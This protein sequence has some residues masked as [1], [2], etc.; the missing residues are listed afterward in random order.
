MIGNNEHRTTKAQNP[1]NDN[2]ETN[3]TSII[4]QS[5]KIR[6]LEVFNMVRTTRLDS[7]NQITT[8]NN[9]KADNF[10]LNFEQKSTQK[11]TEKST[12]LSTDEN[13]YERPINCQGDHSGSNERGERRE[14][15]ESY[16]NEEKLMIFCNT[17]ELLIK[18]QISY[19]KL[20][21]SKIK[22]ITVDKQKIFISRIFHLL[23]KK[24][25]HKVDENFINEQIKYYIV[26]EKIYDEGLLSFI[27]NT[28]NIRVDRD[29]FEEG[30]KSTQLEKR[31]RLYLSIE[32][33]F[34]LDSI[35]N[36]YSQLYSRNFMR[37]IRWY[38][39]AKEYKAKLDRLAF[40]FD[41]LENEFSKKKKEVFLI[42][43]RYSGIKAER[44]LHVLHLLFKNREWKF[45]YCFFKVIS[46]KH[47]G[48]LIWLLLKNRCDNTMRRSLYSIVKFSLNA[49]RTQNDIEILR[50]EKTE[51][52]NNLTDNGI[53]IHDN[54]YQETAGSVTD[55]RADM[56]KVK[57]TLT[58]PLIITRNVKETTTNLYNQ[59]TSTNRDR[60]QL[61]INTISYDDISQPDSFNRITSCSTI[62]NPR[63]SPTHKMGSQLRRAVQLL[64][65]VLKKRLIHAFN[66]INM[67]YK[68][69]TLIERVHAPE[70]QDPNANR[71]SKSAYNQTSLQDIGKQY[72]KLKPQTHTHPIHNEYIV[73]QTPN[74]YTLTQPKPNNFILKKQNPVV[75]EV[76]GIE[77]RTHMLEPK[78]LH[79][80]M[81]NRSIVTSK[82]MLKKSSFEIPLINES[83]NFSAIDQ[84]NRY[85]SVLQNTLRKISTASD[86][87][88]IGRV[89]LTSHDTQSHKNFDLNRNNIMKKSLFMHQQSPKGLDKHR[90][91]PKS[92]SSLFNPNI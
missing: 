82:Q 43:R 70:T 21:L 79:A 72:L 71:Q 92:I 24:Y 32:L 5:D 86:L 57:M 49:R 42:I 4:D 69:L 30:Y 47:R 83:S 74:T 55:K 51:R 6:M 22:Q 73:P 80:S 35:F 68:T 90:P 8:N 23:S 18:N 33:F 2:S 77:D 12:N 7:N 58:G 19:K 63:L 66:K 61:Q 11:T 41:R 25:K 16:F 45:Q 3:T 81:S 88:A 67:Y 36:K 37:C 38:I 14:D 65:S 56:D 17:L 54:I 91:I 53:N 85:H 87:R 28:Q 9:M 60:K 26:K 64:T 76:I 50:Y 62:V 59:A 52:S 89:N 78:T 46:D 1:I 39:D 34:P 20:F 10:S 75:F 15:F 29:E 48:I 40:M 27:N 84:I 31:L 13:T 44:L